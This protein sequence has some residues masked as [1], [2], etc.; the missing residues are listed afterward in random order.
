M[1]NLLSLFRMLNQEAEKMK[2]YIAPEMKIE[3]FSAQDIV[4]LSAI[5]ENLGEVIEFGEEGGSEYK[6]KA[7]N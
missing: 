6:Y 3:K 4:A 2:K 1:L 7:L 5:I